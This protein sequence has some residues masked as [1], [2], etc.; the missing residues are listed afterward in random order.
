[1][2]AVGV[3]ARVFNPGNPRMILPSN[4]CVNARP[5]SPV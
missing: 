3:G 4:G 2:T 1:L 5:A